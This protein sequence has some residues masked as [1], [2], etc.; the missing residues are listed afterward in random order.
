LTPRAGPGRR[1]QSPAGVGHERGLVG[2]H[3]PRRRPAGYG[4][5]YLG[6]A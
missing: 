6:A 1:G 4:V 5:A 2:G 3:R